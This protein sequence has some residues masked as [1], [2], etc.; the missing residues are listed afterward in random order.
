MEQIQDPAALEWYFARSGMHA[1]MP[2]L[3]RYPWVL[4]RYGRGEYICRCGEPVPRLSLLLDGTVLVSITTPQARTYLL[5]FCHPGDL[6]CG[7]VEVALGNTHAT[8]DL[9]VHGDEAWC[10]ELDI[11]RHRA[12]LL[13]DADFLRYALRRVSREMVKDSVYATNNL[14]FRLEDRM[15][16]YI[17]ETSPGGV[18]RENLTRT[19]ELLGVSYR[20]LSRVMKGFRERGWLEKTG[21][22]WRIA[23]PGGLSRLAVDIEPLELK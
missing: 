6:I 13:E 1:R 5:T 10:A 8:A 11:P 7:D 3:R 16:A 20:Q 12:A 18:F 14:L 2:F 15:A 21:D 23:D 9:R 22:G 19:A 4:L 17:L